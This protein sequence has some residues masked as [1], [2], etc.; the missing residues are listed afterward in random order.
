MIR[1]FIAIRIN[2]DTARRITD[3]ISRLRPRV[4]GVRWVP[5]ENFHFTLKF[6]GRVDDEQVVPIHMALVQQLKPFSRFTINA[7][8]LGVF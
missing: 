3:V 5:E 6:L 8:G 2:P 1:A 7:K 4:A